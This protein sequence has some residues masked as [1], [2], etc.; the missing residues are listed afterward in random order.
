MKDAAFESNWFDLPILMKKDLIYI[1]MRSQKELKINVG[2]FEVSLNQFNNVM[3]SSC[4][5]IALLNS[6]IH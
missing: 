3:S 2:V 6:F 4:S 1:M 5:Y